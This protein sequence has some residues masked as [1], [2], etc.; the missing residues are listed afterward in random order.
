MRLAI[1]ATTAMF[2]SGCSWIGWGG[3]SNAAY[4]IGTQYQPNCGGMTVMV[5]CPPTHNGFSQTPIFGAPQTVTG[6]YGTHVNVAGQVQDSTKLSPYAKKPRWRG[7][8]GFGFEK[9]FSGN[10]LDYDTSGFQI[11]SIGYDPTLYNETSVAGSPATGSTTTTTYTA[12]VEEVLG[13]DVS[14]DDVHSTP[15]SIKGGVEYIM[16]PSTTLF[17][18]AGYSYAEGESGGSVIVMGRLRRLETTQDYDPVTGTPLGAPIQNGS[19][20]PNKQIATLNY[21]FS[22][23]HRVDVNLGARRYFMPLYK[24]EL[25]NNLSPF[26]SASLGASH[27]NAVTMKTDQSQLF[28]S[29]A[30]DNDV[31]DYYDVVAPSINEVIYKPQWVPSGELLGGVEWQVSGKSAI[32]LETGLRFEGAR[33]YKTGPRGDMNISIPLTI[34]GSYNF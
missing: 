25:E 19:F 23:M 14:F 8:L 34:R 11:P 18:N 1:C 4:N 16:S 30:F 28:Y 32:A 17:A 6:A 9:S 33:K 21:D 12:V 24:N 27:H 31:L 10:I 7:Q 20:I 26:V 3:S 5:G 13:P 29:R 2:L 22:D 15:F